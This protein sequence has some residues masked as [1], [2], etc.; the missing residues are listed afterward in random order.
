M[1]NKETNVT[2][3]YDK[4][5][6]TTVI[7]LQ[8]AVTSRIC[9]DIAADKLIHDNGDMMDRCAEIINAS[10]VAYHTKDRLWSV[11][12]KEFPS[13]HRR[14]LTLN[15]ACT[16]RENRSILRALKEMLTLT[17]EEYPRE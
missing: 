15:F 3:S 16:D 17:Q 13:V 12:T 5:T 14:L 7:C 1:D 8:T 4:N 2:C 9:V 10:E 11:L 6:N